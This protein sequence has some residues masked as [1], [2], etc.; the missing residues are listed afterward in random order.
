[1]LNNLV[2]AISGGAGRIGSSFSRAIIA[3]GGKVIIGDVSKNKGNKLVQELGAG[4]PWGP[5][6][7]GAVCMGG[8]ASS[9]VLQPHFRRGPP[10]P[11]Q[12][13]PEPPPSPSPASTY[14]ASGGK[15]PLFFDF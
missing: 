3:N 7:G 1:M 2:V 15:N 6:E 10:P 9:R 5:A 14:S 11:Y 8:I 12:I 13:K 4:N